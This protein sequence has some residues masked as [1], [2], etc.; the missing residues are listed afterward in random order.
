MMV[1]ERDFTS[2]EAGKNLRC[3]CVLQSRAV[4]EKYLEGFGCTC[5][6]TPGGH[7]RRAV[8]FASILLIK[9]AL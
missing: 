7:G 2:A 8:R 1:R 9:K 5:T 3:H 4:K 6:R